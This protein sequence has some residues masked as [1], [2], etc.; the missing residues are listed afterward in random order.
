MVIISLIRVLPHIHKILLYLTR[1]ISYSPR[2]R[3]RI[4][5]DREPVSIM[6]GCRSCMKHANLD[7]LRLAFVG[8]GITL[9]H[10]NMPRKGGQVHVSN[11]T[12][13]DVLKSTY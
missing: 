10:T 8:A 1:I 7:Q 4:E 5:M 13:G 11:Q 2:G 12:H 3:L 9:K 6:R